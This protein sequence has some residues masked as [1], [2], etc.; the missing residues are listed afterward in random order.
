MS[1]SSSSLNHSNIYISVKI[2]D[3]SE[4]KKLNKKHLNFD[5]VTDVL[6]FNMN[7]ETEDGYYLGDVIVNKEQAERQ[8]SEY[9]NSVEEEIAQLVEH[10]VL[11]LLGVH[12]DG[13]DEKSVHGVKIKQ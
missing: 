9:G 2:S 13:D 11:H 1:I 12:H 7:E 6:S 5:G 3:D 8:A 10:G 4:I